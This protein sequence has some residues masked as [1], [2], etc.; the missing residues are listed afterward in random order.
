MQFVQ[1]LI[2]R[3]SLAAFQRGII[4]S[5]CIVP[6]CTFN[7]FVSKSAKLYNVRDLLG[8]TANLSVS[9]PF[10]STVARLSV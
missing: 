7:R 2:P 4:K 9:I 5:A 1:S 8:L 6:L 10:D 3:C